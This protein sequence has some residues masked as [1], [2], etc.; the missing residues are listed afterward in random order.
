M[1]AWIDSLNLW[2]SLNPHWLG[3]ATDGVA[4]QASARTMRR[5]MSTSLTSSTS[6]AR[7]RMPSRDEW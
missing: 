6:R 2:L 7:R 5:L 3:A 1:D 4:V